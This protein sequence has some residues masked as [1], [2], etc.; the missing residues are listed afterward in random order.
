MFGNKKRDKRIS[1]VVGTL[2]DLQ[3]ELDIQNLFEYPFRPYS[4]YQRRATKHPLVERLLKLEEYL[5]IEYQEKTETTKGYVKKGR[6]K[7]K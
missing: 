2:V 6:I 3:K 4:S 5:G 1:Y 7:S